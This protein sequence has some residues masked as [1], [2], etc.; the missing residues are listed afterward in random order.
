MTDSD[1]RAALAEENPDALLMDGFDRALVGV[2]RRSGQPT[3]A[4]YDRRLC[5]DVLTR[6]HG[7]EPEEAEEHF[8]FNCAG[9]W[10]G[11]H[12]PAILDRLD[13]LEAPEEARA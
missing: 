7:L 13:G 2:V 1:I 9:A 8:E 12:T 6:D 11:P 3:V 5:L 4:A 10:M